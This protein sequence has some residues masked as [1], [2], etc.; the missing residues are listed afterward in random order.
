MGVTADDVCTLTRS[1]CDQII[2][3]RILDVSRWW[4]GWVRDELRTRSNKRDELGSRLFCDSVAQLRCAQRP[5]HLD[6]ELRTDDE[7]DV[8]VEPVLDQASR[9]ALA[10]QNCRYENVRVWNDAH[11]LCAALGPA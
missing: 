1:E 11:A 8:A 10:G 9:R 6:Q 7:V 4:V 5:L 3:A 2:V